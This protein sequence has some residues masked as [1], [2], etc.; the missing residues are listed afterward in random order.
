ML[1]MVKALEESLGQ[2]IQKR[3]WMTPETKTQARG[4]LHAITNKIWLSG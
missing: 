1:K 2:D 3:N 4:K